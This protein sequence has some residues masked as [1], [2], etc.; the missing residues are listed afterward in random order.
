MLKVI[1]DFYDQGSLALKSGIYL[2]EIA[3]LPVKDK[4][5]RM[6]Y[7]PEEQMNEIDDIQN[8]LRESIAQLISK[9]GILNA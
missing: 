5:A 1:L 2:K 9:G 8:E 7:I 6:K 4:I 3:N